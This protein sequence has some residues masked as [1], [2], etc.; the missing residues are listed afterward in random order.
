MVD[1]YGVIGLS[2]GDEGKGATVDYLCR[3][4]KASYIIRFNGGPQA[5]HNVV[6]PSNRKH[7]FSQFG[8]GTFVP[9]VKTHLGRNMLIEPNN[10]IVENNVLKSI[11][12]ND[13]I[14]RL[15]IEPNCI[16]ITPWNKM[17]GQLKE[18]CRNN[19]RHGSVGMG[20]GDTVADSKQS[21][22]LTIR[23]KDTLFKDKLLKKVKNIY[24]QKMLQ[25]NSLIKDNPK[26]CNSNSIA[27][28]NEY[29]PE[30][31]SEFYH[32]FFSCDS[33]KILSDEKLFSQLIKEKATVIFEGAQGT[34]LDPI[35][36]FKPYITKTPCTTNAIDNYLGSFRPLFNLHNIGVMRAF[37]HRHGP[38]LL[39]TED[40][41]DFFF[42]GEH[43]NENQWQGKFRCGWFDAPMIRHALSNND[44]DSVFLTCMD[45]LNGLNDI[46]VCSHYTLNGK[47]TDVNNQLSL[48]ELFDCEPVY[49]IQKGWKNAG[50]ESSNALNYINYLSKILNVSIEN[51]SI[52]NTF[53]DRI[54]LK[55]I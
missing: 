42:R 22:N 43:N 35:V 18:L 53:T 48:S 52:G 51:M 3:K 50:L 41:N 46:K 10:I 11:G 29:T 26:T 5:A 14:S 15:T 27:K 45:R 16:I 25:A 54:D 38:G 40:N 34:L 2:Y 20:V 21:E 44:I 13:A 24:K 37:A 33:T 9:G 47:T 4:K 17:I 8:S 12:I 7:T 55:H 1:A 19:N 28:F 31:I 23:V 39:S 36:G 30:N 49:E 32:R 6:E